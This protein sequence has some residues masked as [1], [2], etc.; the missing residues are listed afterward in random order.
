MLEDHSDIVIIA[1]PVTVGWLAE[2][3]NRGFGDMLKVVI[4]TKQRVLAVGA[5]LH[6]DEEDLLIQRG[7]AQVDLWG[8]NIFPSKPRSEWIEFDSLINV[9]PRMGNRSRSVEDN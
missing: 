6:S 8:F 7:S 3:A 4:D 2:I 9:R 1:E 5:E